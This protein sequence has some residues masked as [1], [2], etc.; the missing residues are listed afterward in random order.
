MIGGQSRRASVAEA[1][2]NTIVGYALAVLTQIAV[3]PLYGLTVDLHSHLGIGAA[4][5]AVSLLRSYIL[6]RI[7]ER[8]R[9]F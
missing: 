1:I 7:F 3:F 6:R 2:A 8:F 9:K 5:V 4:F